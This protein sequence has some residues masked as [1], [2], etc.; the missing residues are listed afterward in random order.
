MSGLGGFGMGGMG[1]GF[2]SEEGN[3]GGKSSE[4]KVFAPNSFRFFIN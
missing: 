1:G 2:M 3:K 4:K